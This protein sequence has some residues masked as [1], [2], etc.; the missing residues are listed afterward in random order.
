MVWRGRDAVAISR[1]KE[2]ESSNGWVPPQ[3]PGE[4]ATQR[5]LN[6]RLVRNDISKRTGLI[7][8][9]VPPLPPGEIAT[10]C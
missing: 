6:S 5:R 3:P 4:I 10:A 9:L 1:T 7:E 8:W 2:Q